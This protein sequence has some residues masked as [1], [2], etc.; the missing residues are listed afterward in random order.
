MEE[1]GKGEKES[2]GAVWTGGIGRQDCRGK[3]H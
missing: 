2:F 1:F 3:G